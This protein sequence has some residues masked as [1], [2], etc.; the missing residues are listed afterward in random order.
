[1]MNDV[2]T[3]KENVASNAT[4]ISNLVRDCSSQQ[5]TIEAKLNGWG[6]AGEVLMKDLQEMKAKHA[7]LE[8]KVN[9]RRENASM[10]FSDFGDFNNITP[11]KGVF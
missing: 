4:S 1:M 3:L 8:A 10:I 6:E 9:E 7:E 5:A 11:V 2:A